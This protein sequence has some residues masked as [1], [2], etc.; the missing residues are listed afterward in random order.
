MKKFKFRFEKILGFRRHCEMEKQRDLAD[1]LHRHQKQQDA[2]EAICED[3]SGRQTGQ[4]E[5]MTG[6]IQ[7]SRLNGFTRYYLILNLMES[8]GRAV[9]QKISGEV[10]KERE[11]LLEATREKKI[12]EKLKERHWEKYSAEVNLLT[13]KE[14]DDIGQKLYWLK[15]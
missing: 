15:K 10:D 9:L 11:S 14:M 4:R 7:P 13:Q 8:S 3:R 1:V 6:V 5:L 12:Y 2:I